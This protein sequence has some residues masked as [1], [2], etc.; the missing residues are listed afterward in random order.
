VGST[1]LATDPGCEGNRSYR[2]LLYF[3]TVFWIQIH[4][5]RIQIQ[6][7]YGIR[8]LALLNPDPDPG[9]YDKKVK[10]YCMLVLLKPLKGICN[11]RE[12]K[13]Q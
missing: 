8:I 4:G 13:K 3:S 10:K 2:F 7:F 12:G 9:F 6:A 1:G 11:V 5:F